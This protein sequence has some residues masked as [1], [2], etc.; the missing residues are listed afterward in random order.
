MTAKQDNEAVDVAAAGRAVYERLRER[1][2]AEAWGRVVVID[3]KSG[4]YEI[5]ENHLVV[6]LRLRERRPGAYT[7]AERVGY[8]TVTRLGAGYRPGP[9]DPPAGPV[10]WSDSIANRVCR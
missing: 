3:V 10:Q 6:A 2:E 4:D 1:L 9:A 8:P 7:W 5:A